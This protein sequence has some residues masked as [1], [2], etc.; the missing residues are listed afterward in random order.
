MRVLMREDGKAVVRTWIA[1]LAKRTHQALGTLEQLRAK[2]LEADGGV[3]IVAQGHLAGLKISVQK[4]I[5]GFSQQGD[6][7]LPIAL[8]TGLEVSLKSLVSTMLSA[9]FLALFAIAPVRPGLED[10]ALLEL[11]RPAGE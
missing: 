11:L 3:D 5:E 4:R 10:V 2:L 6:P 7:N 8:S 1:L 9:C